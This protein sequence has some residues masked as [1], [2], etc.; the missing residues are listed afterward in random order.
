MIKVGLIGCGGIGSFTAEY[1]DKSRKFKL[2]SLFDIN[3]NMA[4]QLSKRLRNKPQVVGSV[5]SLLKNTDLVIEAASQEVVKKHSIKILRSGRDLMIVSVGALV[6]KTLLG[7][8]KKEAEKNKCFVYLPSGA[9]CGVDGVKAAS[10]GK[11]KHITLTTTKN[12]KTL[13]DIE[14]LKKKGV[15]LSNI[16]K[17]VVVYSGSARQAVKLFPKNINVSATLGL[18]GAGLDKT[19]VKIIADPNVKEN[20]HEFSLKGDCGQIYVKLVNVPSPNNPKT[21]YIT[22]LSV[23]KTLEQI[24]SRVKI[25]T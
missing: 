19:Q 16:N 17:P 4:L 1:L 18:V 13:A 20:I 11:I 8:I 5:P 25:G 6:D 3:K 22:C 2:V 24:V 9:I 15:D 7:R 12:P 14:Y 21:S 23:V 10:A